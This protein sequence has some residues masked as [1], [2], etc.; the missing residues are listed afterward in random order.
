[1]EGIGGSLKKIIT[2]LII[3]GLLT[4]SFGISIKPA[5]AASTIVETGD[6]GSK[7]VISG[8]IIAF[9]DENQHL[10]YF[11]ILNQQTVHT[12]VSVQT[13]PFASSLSISGSLI[14]FAF[15]N[16][17]CYYDI[18]TNSLVNTGI[19][20]VFP[21]IDGNKIAF[22]SGRAY[23]GT[24]SYYDISTK[25]LTPIDFPVYGRPSISNSI[26]AF[27]YSGLLF[28]YNI[29]SNTLTN[30]DLR[31]YCEPSISG[32]KIAFTTTQHNYEPNELCIF[33][34][35]NDA[36][37]RTGIFGYYN[38]SIEGSMVVFGTFLP[39]YP[40]GYYN[41]LTGLSETVENTGAF[42]FAE[43]WQTPS[44]DNNIITWANENGLIY[45]M[46]TSQ[47]TLDTQTGSDITIN[48]VG[49]GVSVTYSDVVSRRRNHSYFEFHKSWS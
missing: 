16:S 42:N 44:I 28:Y 12:E 8:S 30:S 32:S 23:Q 20:G 39:T 35:S 48:S 41:I 21:S 1:M 33:D 18:S 27:T 47:S 7:P 2:F 6:L 4:V 46:D 40:L 26:I 22:I 14:A 19:N 13:N 11:N 36:I 25:I 15:D 10:S 17:I 45:Y 9:V 29:T 34:A 37:I 24:L 38:V 49:S 5:N 43:N 3:L 31:C